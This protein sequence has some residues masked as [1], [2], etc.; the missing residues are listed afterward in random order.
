M[1]AATVPAGGG[2]DKITLVE[3]EPG[4]PGPGQVQ[5]RWRATSLN[6]HDYLVAAGQIPV[7]DGRIPMSDGAGEIT[8]VGE[9]VADWQVGDH[10]MST[11]FPF[12]QGGAPT[13][14][15][16]MGVAGETVD[17]F[18]IEAS[19]VD[20]STLT[21][22]PA[23]YSFAEAATL[24]CA[25]LTAWRALVEEGGLQPGQSVLVEGSGGMSVF[26]LQMAKAA[27]ATVIATTSSDD[28]ADRLRELGADHVVNYKTD[29]RWG[30]SAAK[31]VGGGVDIVLDVG[32]GA[33]IKQST[34][35]VAIG[36]SIILI[37]ILGGRD[38]TI[39]FPKYFF[40]QA[41]MIGIAVGSH[42]M[43]RRMVRGIDVA[44]LKPVIDNRFPLEALGEAFAYQISGAHF[45]KIVVKY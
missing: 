40:K 3:R 42:E 37:G 6:F 21:G 23:G 25:A 9:G 20:A 7:Q 8:A 2:L 41:K 33:T 36:G 10:V 32:G 44:G 22:I 34:E 26:A 28:K 13:L 4:A 17:G 19:N 27:G 38:G 45:G 35:A 18:A 29:E 12:W 15:K 43:Q 1:R 24:P 16:L 14:H 30:K 39:T 5:V 31:L 11:F